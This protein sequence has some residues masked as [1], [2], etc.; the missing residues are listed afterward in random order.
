MS[1]YRY[2]TLDCRYRHY[3]Y[4][5]FQI[6]YTSYIFLKYNRKIKNIPNKL[7]KINDSISADYN[8]F[9]FCLN[10]GAGNYS[11]INFNKAKI[12]LVYIFPQPS[13]Y[14]ILDNSFVNLS[15]NVVYTMDKNIKDYENQISHMITK[16][17]CFYLGI[18]IIILFIFIFVKFNIY[19]M[20]KKYCFSILL[21]I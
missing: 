20:N 13:P 18:Y 2:T 4:I 21:N 10:K 6:L 16:N 15:F 1:K 8:S 7:I 5:Q 14:E 9:L 17:E 19:V 11:F 3:E 12:V